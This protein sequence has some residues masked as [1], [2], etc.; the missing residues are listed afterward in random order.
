MQNMHDNVE[1]K[2]IEILHHLPL[3]PSFSRL[4]LRKGFIGRPLCVDSRQHFLR[5]LLRDP[6]LSSVRCAVR[7]FL[8]HDL[9]EHNQ[10][11]GTSRGI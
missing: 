9:S 11:L 8:R 7:L 1:R 4:N 5:V 10:R 6:R 3:P 2:N